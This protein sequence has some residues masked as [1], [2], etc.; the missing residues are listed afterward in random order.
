MV[1]ND[2]KLFRVAAKT[3]RERGHLPFLSL[4]IENVTA[5]EII[6]YNPPSL[7]LTASLIL[8]T[9]HAEPHCVALLLFSCPAVADSLWTAACQAECI[10]NGN[11]FPLSIETVV[12]DNISLILQFM[13]GQASICDISFLP[14]N[15]IW[16]HCTF[17]MVPWIKAI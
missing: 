15:I 16:W 14:R 4:S 2:Q 5:L 12:N 1:E 6:L 13:S 8:W 9:G 3:P 7:W 17:P 10:P 11:Y